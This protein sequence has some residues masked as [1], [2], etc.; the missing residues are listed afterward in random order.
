M[1]AEVRKIPLPDEDATRQ[2]AV[3][4]AGI[5]LHASAGLRRAAL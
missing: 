1:S 5:L 4:V 2:L 3:A